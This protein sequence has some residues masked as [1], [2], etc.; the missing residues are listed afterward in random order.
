MNFDEEQMIDLQIDEVK[1]GMD[2]MPFAHLAA[3]CY[4]RP[5]SKTMQTDSFCK[6]NILMGPNEGPLMANN[7]AMAMDGIA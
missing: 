5:Y 6:R 1:T 2:A 4:A 7:G 3:E